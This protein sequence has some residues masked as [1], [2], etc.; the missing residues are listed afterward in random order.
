MLALF[1][2][3]KYL[4]ISIII[5]ILDGVI[6]YFMPSYFNKLNFFYPMLTISLI[7]FLYQENTRKYYQL[8]FFLGIIYD[9]LYSNLFLFHPLVF[10]LLGKI[11]IY[12]LKFLKNNMIVYYLLILINILIY[13][14]IL[15]IL[16]FITNYEIVTI[17]DYIYKIR[18]S[19]INI[20]FGSFYYLI[21]NK[22]I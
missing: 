4:I 20:I 14:G 21:F 1:K 15:F 8:L 5:I 22:S 3:K 12:V 9:L 6:V 7:P 13:D 19:L 10:L 18:N 17:N 2:E 16:V 11:D